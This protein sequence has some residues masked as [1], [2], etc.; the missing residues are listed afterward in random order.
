MTALS[1]KTQK[2]HVF[3]KTL[4][5]SVQK[6][7]LKTLYEKISEEISKFQT[8][9]PFLL[10]FD[11]I[12]VL[13]SLGVSITDIQNF[14]HYC[15][16]T[17]CAQDK[18]LYYNLNVY[19]ESLQIGAKSFASLLCERLFKLPHLLAIPTTFFS[20]AVGNNRTAKLSNLWNLEI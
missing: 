9:E 17:A 7:S 10:L 4:S 6:F 16:I 2:M 18:V 15:F 19:F 8:D 5:F 20:P 11:D 3:C 13:L 1:D 12:S 14:V